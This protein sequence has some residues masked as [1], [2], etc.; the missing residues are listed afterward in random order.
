MENQTWNASSTVHPLLEDLDTCLEVSKAVFKGVGLPLY[1]VSEG[2][3]NYVIVCLFVCLELTF[4]R[5]FFTHM[6]TSL[7]PVKPLNRCYFRL[8][9]EMGHRC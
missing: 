6:E 8:N 9:L 3:S 2:Y 4:S 1:A 7:L 5:E